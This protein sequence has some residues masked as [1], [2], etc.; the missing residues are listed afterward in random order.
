MSRSAIA[1]KMTTETSPAATSR[2]VDQ[3]HFDA[4]PT[5]RQRER[6]RHRRQ[7][8]PQVHRSAAGPAATDL[9]YPH[10]STTAEEQ[11]EA[12]RQWAQEIA[13]PVIDVL[14]EA[15]RKA[16]EYAEVGQPG[17]RRL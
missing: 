11:I 1:G 13:A 9:A 5:D 7:R 17:S 14:V 10:S 3:V 4:F 15:V 16:R 12:V 2:R 8:G 6:Q